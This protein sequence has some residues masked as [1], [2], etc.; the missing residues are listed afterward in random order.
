MSVQSYLGERW[1]V[2]VPHVIR[3]EGWNAQDR[4]FCFVSHI[5]D[6]SLICLC[7]K[8]IDDFSICSR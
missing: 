6:E 4:F 7:S 8:D 2:E 5:L 3:D 1:V